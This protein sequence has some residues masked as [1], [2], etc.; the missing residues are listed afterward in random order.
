MAVSD[1]PMI[2]TDA[3]PLITCR[4]VFWF[5]CIAAALSFVWMLWYDESDLFLATVI[6]T[7][8]NL[9]EFV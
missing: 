7:D 4:S 5:I 1:V 6:V 8:R 3:S 9:A 2:P